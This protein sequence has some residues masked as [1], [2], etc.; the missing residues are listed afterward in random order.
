MIF[1]Q[2]TKIIVPKVA[3]PLVSPLIKIGVK[4]WL[5]FILKYLKF[6]Y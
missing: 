6:S 2:K 1:F 5:I 4:N 3:N